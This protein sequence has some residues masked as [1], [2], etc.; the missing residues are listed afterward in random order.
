MG[1]FDLIRKKKPQGT[2]AANKKSDWQ[3][4]LTIALNVKEHIKPIEDVIVGCAC[5]LEQEQTVDTEIEILQK[6]IAHYELA[7]NKCYAL[8]DDYV[9]YFNTTWEMALKDKPDGP[10][11]V[12]RYQNRLK[13]MGEHYQELKETESRYMLQS[14]N[15]KSRLKS[16]LQENAP[17]LQAEIYKSFG[18]LVKNDIRNLLYN[19]EQNGEI[20]R[21]KSGRSYVISL[22]K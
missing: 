3:K 21:E 6:L 10:S 2:N 8:G 20:R 1:L 9:A 22:I 7:R 4:D 12:A 14:E 5:A 17:I 15:L 18:D 19:M 13:Y 16:Y 11:Y